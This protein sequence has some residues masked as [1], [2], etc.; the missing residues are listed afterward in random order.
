MK[1]ASCEKRETSEIRQSKNKIEEQR[2]KMKKFFNW[3][4]EKN[5]KKRRKGKIIK[6]EK[7]REKKVRKRHIHENCKDGK[8]WYGR[9]IVKVRL[10]E[11]RRKVAKIKRIISWEKKMT[12]IEM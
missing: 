10:I 11:K 5:C 1:S 3:K 12:E 7:E 2:G 6:K 4:K 9:K 8:D